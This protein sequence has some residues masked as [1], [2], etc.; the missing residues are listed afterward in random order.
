M[1]PDGTLAQR[2]DYDEF[3]NVLTNSA[4]GLQPFGFAGGLVD[5]DTGLV[6]FGARDY[7]SVT[8]RWT[9]KDPLRFGG[10]SAD[11]Y[12]YV[13]SDPINLEDPNGLQTC[14]P[15]SSCE[16]CTFNGECWICPPGKHPRESMELCPPDF[17]D[18]FK[19]EGQEPPNPPKPE[20][21]KPEVQCEPDPPMGKAKKP[22]LG[23]KG[24]FDFMMNYC[25][26]LNGSVFRAAC[27]AGATAAWVL[28][29]ARPH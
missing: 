7:D 23:C 18:K 15:G 26:S 24:E 14:P 10:G 21:L 29:M 27:A 4:P 22:G 1:A 3:G 17:K 16:G 12:S 19:T 20:D 5:V 6:R 13:T 28:C 9:A 11:L 25:K 2:L 8:G